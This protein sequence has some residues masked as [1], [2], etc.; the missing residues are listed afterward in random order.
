MTFT[1]RTAFSSL[2]RL[3]YIGS[4]GGLTRKLEASIL[5]TKV[6]IYKSVPILTPKNY[7]LKQ[8]RNYGLLIFMLCNFLVRTPQCTESMIFFL[9]IKTALK[10]YF[11]LILDIFSTIANRPKTSRNLKFCFI[12]MAHRVTYIF[13]RICLVR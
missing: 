10:T 12:K 6:F 13:K 7:I 8:E 9:P 11:S 1:R 2:F 3:E 4:D 5:S